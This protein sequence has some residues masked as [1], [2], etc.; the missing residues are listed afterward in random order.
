VLKPGQVLLLGK[1]EIRL[2]TGAAP[3]PMKK[4]VDQTLVMPRGV[5]LEQLEQG[6]RASGFDT[7][8]KAFSKK[9]NRINK[10]FIVV[11]VIMAVV[12]VVLLII[13]FTSIGR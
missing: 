4:P 3:G 1:V 7:T 6:T 10:M 13:A 11:G 12:I 8:S 9:D 2:E 5:S